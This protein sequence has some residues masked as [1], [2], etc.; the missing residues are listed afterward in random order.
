MKYRTGVVKR[1]S[2][3]YVFPVNVYYWYVTLKRDGEKN[4]SYH[5]DDAD[6]WELIDP[7]KLKLDQTAQ[8]LADAVK[9]G[10]MTAA[11]PLADRVIELNGGTTSAA[12]VSPAESSDT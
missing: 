11:L 7:P 10:D 12:V 3:E 2:L 6:R 4:G 5:Y 9:A 1:I 8:L